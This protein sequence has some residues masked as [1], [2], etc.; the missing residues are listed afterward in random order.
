M[1]AIFYIH[2]IKG[3]DYIQNRSVFI[4]TNNLIGEV[5]IEKRGEKEKKERKSSYVAH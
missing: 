5:E 3:K 4:S 2:N 1:R